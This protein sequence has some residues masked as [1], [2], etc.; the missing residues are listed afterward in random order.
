MYNIYVNRETGEEVQLISDAGCVDGTFRINYIKKDMILRSMESSEFYRKHVYKR[1][2]EASKRKLISIFAGLLMIGCS[3]SKSNYPDVKTYPVHGHVL[4][5]NGKPLPGGHIYLVPNKGNLTIIPNGRVNPDGSF[6]IKSGQLGD[7]APEG[8]YKI[9]IDPGKGFGK[10][11]MDEDTSSLVC[12][13]TKTEN[14]ITL[15]LH[16]R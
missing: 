5:A 14:E 8:S 15:V 4:L 12:D 7:G 1:D 9:R 10:R 11:Y 2:L 6:E 13:V 3:N 16:G